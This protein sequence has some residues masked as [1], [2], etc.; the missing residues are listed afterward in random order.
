MMK[1]EKPSL[2][3]YNFEVGVHFSTKPVVDELSRGLIVATKFSTVPFYAADFVTS[4]CN[5]LFLI[6]ASSSI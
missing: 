2:K 6:T 3:L 1:A 4:T 5:L